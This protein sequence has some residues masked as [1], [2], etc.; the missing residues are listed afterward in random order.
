MLPKGA[1]D[2]NVRAYWELYEWS[3]LDYKLEL[4]LRAPSSRISGETG[5]SKEREGTVCGEDKHLQQRG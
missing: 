3:R 4:E 5:L 1:A 2:R